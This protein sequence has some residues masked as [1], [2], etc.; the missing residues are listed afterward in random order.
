MEY[1]YSLLPEF[2]RRAETLLTEGERQSLILH[3]AHH[4]LAGVVVQGTGGVRKLR[5][6]AG[7]KGKRGGVRILYYFYNET[8]PLFLLT[9][10][11][12][13]VQ[14]DLSKAEQELLAKLSTHLRYNYGHSDV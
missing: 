10:F 7:Q 13:S 1:E 9:L 5:W 2:Q 6:A 4:P 12:K 14:E 11:A 8:M 3:L